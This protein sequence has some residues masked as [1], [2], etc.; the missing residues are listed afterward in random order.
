MHLAWSRFP[1]SRFHAASAVEIV[2]IKLV[3]DA[4]LLTAQW[5]RNIAN[6]EF[7]FQP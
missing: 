6:L 4:W 3:I 1:R 2:K 5:S 7:R